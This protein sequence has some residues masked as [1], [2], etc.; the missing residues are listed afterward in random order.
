MSPVS[1]LGCFLHRELQFN[2]TRDCV[3]AN[4][5]SSGQVP[6]TSAGLSDDPSLIKPFSALMTHGWVCDASEA[7]VSQSFGEDLLAKNFVKITGFP[8]FWN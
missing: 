8:S 1:S 2:P 7:H 5:L 3:V 4:A 6:G